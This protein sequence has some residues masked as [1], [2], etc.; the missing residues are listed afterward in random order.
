MGK[1]QSVS[2]HNN[3]ATRHAPGNT[4]AMSR[5]IGILLMLMVAA[6]VAKAAPPVIALPNQPPTPG[7]TGDW[8]GERSK[9]VSEGLTVAAAIYEDYSKNF[10]GGVS[11]SQ[12]ASREFFDLDIT[13]TTDQLLHWHGGTFFFN[14]LDHE[15]TDGTRALTGDAQ[16]FDNQDGPRS[17]QIYQLYYQQMLADDT[18]RVKIGRIDSTTDF[19]FVTY[20]SSFLG[21]SFGYSPAIT[22][23]PTYPDPAVGAAVFW[24]PGEHLYASGGVAYAN[25]S[26]RSGILSGAPYTLRGS[27]G[28][29][30]LVTEVG[31]KWTIGPDKLAGRLAVGGYHHTGTFQRFDGEDQRGASGMFAVFD[32]TIW[33][34]RAPNPNS[35]DPAP[36]IGI[37]AQY[38]LADA[39]I[40]VIDQHVGVG[41]QWTGPIPTN[42]RASDV[43]GAGASCVHL[44]NQAGLSRDYE[45]AIEAF[46]KLQFTPWLSLQPDLQFIVNPGGGTHDALVG[47]VRAELDF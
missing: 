10:Q 32:Q 11:T 18:L 39:D 37:F 29:V 38:G 41:L 36:S 9:L 27:S 31:A 20:G 14:F 17:D 15:G 44:S 19:A 5:A 12:Y 42:S 13:F 35:G 45:L 43:L 22:S 3:I 4:L 24:T 1:E 26:D 2:S 46:Y 28:G 21:S 6:A 25:H 34:R 47:T 7:V 23:F 30:F 8:G 40:S 16:G 33:Q